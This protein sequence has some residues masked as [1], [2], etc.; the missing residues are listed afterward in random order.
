MYLKKR[1]TEL[2]R[3]WN[4]CAENKINIEVNNL[5]NYLIFSNFMIN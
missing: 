3:V 5:L 1:F 2:K 4:K